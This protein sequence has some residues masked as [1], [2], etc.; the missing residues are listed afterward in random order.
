M[1]CSISMLSKSVHLTLLS[2]GTYSPRHYLYCLQ[3]ALEPLKANRIEEA[4]C[5]IAAA[6][7]LSTSTLSDDTNDQAVQG[8]I[9]RRLLQKPG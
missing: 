6:R 7:L 5:G 3:S 1:C 2:H 4:Y 9:Y 8:E